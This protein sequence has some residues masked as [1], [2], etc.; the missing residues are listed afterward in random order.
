MNLKKQEHI[1]ELKQIL[2]SP[3]AIAAYQQNGLNSSEMVA[4]QQYTQSH[5][6]QMKMVK[7][8]SMQV[9]VKNTVYE[10][11]G[12][13]FAGPCLLIYANESQNVSAVF[14]AH[15]KFSKLVPLGAI[16]Q[17]GYLSA[18]DFDWVS[19]MTHW[20]SVYGNIAHS[21]VNSVMEL[22]NVLDLPAMELCY[23]SD[24]VQKTAE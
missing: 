20:N 19:Q 3:N 16:L 22:I 6:L 23:V 21:S 7:N 18:M 9:A 17:K 12:T 14:A 1:E 11:F 5:S 8:T 24:H 15:K 13:L 4:L 10:N 2:Q